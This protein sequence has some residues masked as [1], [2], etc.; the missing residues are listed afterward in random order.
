MN[1][2]FFRDERTITDTPLYH[3]AI[4]PYTLLPQITLPTLVGS[5]DL[6]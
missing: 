4:G 3:Y 6:P 1:D 2:H 5:G